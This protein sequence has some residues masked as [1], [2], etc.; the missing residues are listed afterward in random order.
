MG[1][2]FLRGSCKAP[3]FENHLAALTILI[4][5]QNQMRLGRT[6]QDAPQM[7]Q[8]AFGIFLER[9]SRLGVPEGDIHGNRR[10]L[11]SYVTSFLSRCSPTLLVPASFHSHSRSLPFGSVFYPTRWRLP[12]GRI[13]NSCR[14]LPTC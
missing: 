4:D 10:G 7:G 8:L 6:V 13:P 1:V 5:S 3:R 2:R 12:E 11:S 9:L 14:S